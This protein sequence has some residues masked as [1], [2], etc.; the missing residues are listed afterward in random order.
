MEGISKDSMPC[1]AIARNSC[2]VHVL[3][4]SF[5]VESGRIEEKRLLD[6]MASGHNLL[7]L[8]W[9]ERVIKAF[10]EAAPY[11]FPCP[12]FNLPLTLLES[13]HHTWGGVTW[14]W[15]ALFATHAVALPPW[16]PCPLWTRLEGVLGH[17]NA[18][19]VL[20][21]ALKGHPW[22]SEILEVTF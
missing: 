4:V 16:S 10:I 7:G 17:Q 22:F 15:A 14:P 12:A 3:F 1:E 11:G 9:L 19:Q 21:G 13:I 20:Q 5:Q 18:F 8:L 6:Q 2:W